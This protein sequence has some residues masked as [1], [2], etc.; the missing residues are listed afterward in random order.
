MDDAAASALWEAGAEKMREVY[1]GRV[2]VMPE[3]SMPFNDVMLRTLFAQVW[4]RPQLE[5]RDRRLLLIGVIAAMGERDT[6]RIQCRAAL[7]NGELTPEELRETLIMLAPYAGYPRVAGLVL[8]VEEVIGE[9][10]R[11]Q[12]D[13]AAD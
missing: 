2:P 10:Q 9:W 6:F 8:P 13:A 5:M 3:G 4:D 12:A 11:E 1:D 7:D